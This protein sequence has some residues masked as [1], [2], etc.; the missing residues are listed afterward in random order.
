MVMSM[1]MK[2][3]RGDKPAPDDAS[4][5]APAESPAEGSAEASA[6]STEA[7]GPTE[8]VAG[9]SEKDAGK[10]SEKTNGTVPGKVAQEAPAKAPPAIPPAVPVLKFVS[11]AIGA[12]RALSAEALRR[13]VDPATLGFKT[14]SEIEPATGLVGQDRALDAIAF[15]TGMRALDFNVFV[16]GPPAAGKSTAVRTYLA[17]PAASRPRPSDWV[18]VH[19]FET[20]AAPNAIPLP[21]GR[22]RP[23]AKAMAAALE[24]LAAT[25]PAV[26][27]G[28]DYQG[29]RRA[30]DEEF[31]AAQEDAFTE[32]THR[33]EAQNVT[34]LRTPGG[35]VMAPMHEGEVVKPEMF[36]ALP[37]EY[38]E[39]IARR[40]EELQK[41]LAAIIEAA[42]RSE[43]ERRKR[44]AALNAEVSKRV[45][46]AALAPV[47][48]AFGELPEVAQYLASVGT[49]LIGDI[50]VFLSSPRDDQVVPEA[51]D[52]AR[53]PRLRRFLVNVVVGHDGEEAGAPIHEELNPT[54]SN[55]VGRIEHKAQMGALVTDFLL[56]S[57]GALHRANGGYLLLD[58]RKLILSAFSWEA[59]KRA[60]KSGEI[61][62]EQPSE[63][64]SVLSTETLQ[65]EPIPLDVKVILFGD[66][67]IYT[68][69]AAADPEFS[70]LF[71][72][73][74]DFDD[75]IER[76]ATNDRAIGGLVASIV[77][78][79]ALKPVTAA[80][81]ARVIEQA[82][83]LANDRDKVSIEI[84]R[85]ADLVREAD[86]W[87][88]QADRDV[89]DASDVVKAV[90]SARQ[91]ADRI[92]E[93][94][95]ETISRGIV[96]IDTDGGKV[97]Q[98]N[99]LSVIQL[100]D[101]A[102]G[103]PVRISARV[104]FG[105]GRVTDIER[106]A[107]LGGPL[108][109]KGV[110]LLWGYLAGRYA[111]DSPLAL[112]ASLV[113]EQSYGGV[114]GDSASSAELYALLSALAEV[115]IDQGL[116][117]TGSVNQWGEVQ[118]IGGVNEKVEGFFDICKARGLNGRQGV[119][120]PAANVQ[121]LMLRD[122]I[123]S[124]AREG[125]FKIYPVATIDEGIAVLTGMPAGEHGGSGKF[126]EATLNRL[127]EDK[128]A[129]YAQRAR[130]EWPASGRHSAGEEP[131]AGESS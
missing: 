76:S 46:D 111:L 86:Y 6:K 79:H 9:P 24:E 43:K 85:I 78:R 69:L 3:F 47:R 96:L 89:V 52:T 7:A 102:F 128:L 4:A 18:Y 8:K 37:Q 119:L 87:A 57:P 64:A 12:P 115:P 44:L 53:D 131:D 58:A 54:Y 61:R 116:A 104:R 117:V 60:L 125:K 75:A 19:N 114:E 15:G 97:G 16:L 59:L 56:V 11:D 39:D 94:S 118:A 17:A 65:P 33:A 88:A 123:V 10:A 41:E 81:V 48:A 107:K 32:L 82:A 13:T 93:R 62:I 121:H 2:W 26:F 84:G 124:A 92:R 45:V 31:R 66:R 99:G 28:E 126:P 20:P 67:E 23:F 108:H 55:L 113:F 5:E 105:S 106:E 98:V 1:L 91:R 49:G 51:L 22:A 72:V 83:R 73:Q 127:V 74:A 110:M 63:F 95:Q 68:L 29:R 36:A 50:A 112:A 101:L 25:V 42:P 34:I 122:D 35:F 21:A 77:Q 80:G 27:E 109:T 120:V 90:D 30:V 40:I 70:R 14:T 130:R 103:R 100:G 38:R 129:L 71:K